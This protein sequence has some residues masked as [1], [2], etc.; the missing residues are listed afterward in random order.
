MLL[1]NAHRKKGQPSLLPKDFFPSLQGD[2]N[3]S[4]AEMKDVFGQLAAS[5]GGTTPGA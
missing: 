2:Q 5:H 4:P 1:Q 3:Q